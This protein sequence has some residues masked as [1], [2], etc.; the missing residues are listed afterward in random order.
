[1]CGI[2]G[3]WSFAAPDV[4]D[5]FVQRSIHAL[6]HRGPDGSGS[7]YDQTASL[8]LGHTRLAVIDT[9]QLAA[10]PMTDSTGRWTVVFNGE[11]YNYIEIKRAL[12]RLGRRFETESDT[13]VLL[14]AFIEWGPA[15]QERFNG[16]W[17]FAVWDA[18][19]SELFLSRDRFGVKPLYI[20]DSEGR[21]VFGSE[22]KVF[23]LTGP[24]VDGF[25]RELYRF[26]KITELESAGLTILRGVS[27]VPPGHQ[28]LVTAS[29]SQR[30][31]R[32]WNTLD[33]LPAV[34][35]RYVERV[36]ELRG[37][38]GDA[39]E[40]RLR[41][42]VPVGTSLSGGLDSSVIAAL[43]HERIQSHHPNLAQKVYTR[44][45]PGTPMDEA[46]W[47]ER[48]ASSLGVDL[49]RTNHGVGEALD[50]FEE[51]VHV[52][53]DAYLLPLG[54]WSHYRGM[55]LDGTVVSID[56]HGADELFAGYPSTVRGLR[57][58]SLQ[59]GRISAWRELDR[60]HRR[61]KG[62]DGS[63][64][65]GRMFG[66]VTQDAMATARMLFQ[67]R[68]HRTRPRKRPGSDGVDEILEALR[69]RADV[70][71][72]EA[73]ALSPLNRI[74]YSEFHHGMLPAVLRNFDRMSMAN[75]IEIRS[76]Y[77]DWRVVTYA[78]A[79]PDS[80]K[81]GGGFSKRI[82]R[83]VGSAYLPEDVTMRLDKIGFR[84]PVSDLMSDGLAGIAAQRLASGELGEVCS[85]VGVESADIARALQEQDWKQLAHN[86]RFV[87]AAILL[88]MLRKSHDA[89]SKDGRATA[90]ALE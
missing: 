25:R 15:C 90:G 52:L 53:E 66:A 30:V 56:G 48:V 26:S 57:R 54:V 44:T 36:E 40:L 46:H 29:G 50:R 81:I 67:W 24:W 84:D 8:R 70:V 20:G 9:R 6:G 69:S 18:A 43:V 79:L 82:L 10:Q 34:S 68:P 33:H 86:W 85:A 13:E 37:R 49:I 89:I 7:F 11:I 58:T 19:R 87:Q 51:I 71:A 80:D 62:E 45:F 17:A 55:R 78:F 21:F 31:A 61:L 5:A 32:W 28:V 35:P 72:A 88:R 42:D 23:A 75:G 4:G 64:S 3:V 1:M 63:V 73:R 12:E 76:P 59:L 83:D 65:M 14:Q 74:L 60:L 41:S 27:S 2:V 16:M 47:A 38:L 22:V 39:C 77:L